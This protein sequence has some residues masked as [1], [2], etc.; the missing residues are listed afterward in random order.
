L[1]K[2]DLPE[3][4]PPNPTVGILIVEGVMSSDSKRLWSAEVKV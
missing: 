3:T 4:D 2:S 1:F